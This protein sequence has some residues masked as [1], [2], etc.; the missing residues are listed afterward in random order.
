MNRFVI[1]TSVV[2][3]WFFED[4]A[5]DYT[6]AILEKLK[7]HTCVVP[8]LWYLEVANTL[9]SGERRRRSSKTDATRFIT[10]LQALPIETDVLTAEQALTS[11]LALA[12]EYSLSA[13]DAAYLEL[14]IRH[15]IPLATQ[16]KK[17]KD[18]VRKAG[19]RIFLDQ[20]HL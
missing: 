8:S 3:A 11:T 16:D 20:K 5:N 12:R 2:M 14:A 6:I 10:L 18:A 13:Y 9:L 4:E 19:A 17:L 7:T 1:D 15:G